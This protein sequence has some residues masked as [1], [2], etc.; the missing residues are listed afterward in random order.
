MLDR[1]DRM[2]LVVRDRAKAAETFARVLAAKP[3]REAVDGEPVLAQGWRAEVVGQLLDDL[4]AGK[5]AIRIEDP[6]SDQP[7]SFEGAS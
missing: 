4:L 6:H 5:V 2:L 1:L 7:F 3:V